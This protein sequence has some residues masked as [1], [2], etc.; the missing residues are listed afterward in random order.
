M[1]TEAAIQLRQCFELVAAIKAEYPEGEFDRE[2][3]HGDLEFRYQ[4]I[5]RLREQLQAL[6]LA[7][8]EFARFKDALAVSDE[9][10][11]SFLQLVLEDPDYFSGLAG[12]GFRE[13][14]VKIEVCSRKLGISAS[15]IDRLF[16]RARLTGILNS[17]YR[18]SEDYRGVIAAYLAL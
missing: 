6:P 15:I 14:R 8:R 18:L 5:K 9:A 1:S 17:D 3:L 4:H 7:V 10:V 11:R 2:M 16:A 12:L 13:M